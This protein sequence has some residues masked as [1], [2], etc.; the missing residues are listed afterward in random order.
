MYE[1]I[2]VEVLS[3]IDPKELVARRSFPLKSLTR[4]S[5]VSLLCSGRD[6]FSAQTSFTF[7]DVRF[8]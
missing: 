7:F 4:K 6:L 5:S 2:E 1:E 8:Q 3:G